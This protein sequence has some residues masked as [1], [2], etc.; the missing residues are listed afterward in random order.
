M[1]ST[2]SVRVIALR[3]Y[4]FVCTS[5]VNLLSPN[6]ILNRQVTASKELLKLSLVP[7]AI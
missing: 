2:A 3:N 1:D 6:Q 4:F 7:R 5:R